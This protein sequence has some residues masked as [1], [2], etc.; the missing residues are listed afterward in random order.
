MTPDEARKERERL[1]E[2]DSLTKDEVDNLSSLT[3]LAFSDISPIQH[4]VSS[5]A[6]PPQNGWT[7][8]KWKKLH[9][10]VLSMLSNIDVKIY[11]GT[12][13]P[14]I[15]GGSKVF[16]NIEEINDEMKKFNDK[17]SE[18]KEIKIKRIMP[19]TKEKKIAE[20]FASEAKG[21]KTD[22]GYTFNDGF[23]H[24]IKPSSDTKAVDVSLEV[25]KTFKNVFK[26]NNEMEVSKREKEVLVIPGTILRPISKEGSIYTWE[27]V[28]IPTK[29]KKR[30]TRK[31]KKH[32]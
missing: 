29:S 16:K 5:S 19:F 24:I 13:F 11:R 1:L 26:H 20:R 23:I 3:I 10:Q 15:E 2:K 12:K 22:Q 6:G 9:E 27:I 14:W 17:F 18:K 28:S 4:W 32:Y 7:K 25:S 30:K 21:Y 8:L 31:I